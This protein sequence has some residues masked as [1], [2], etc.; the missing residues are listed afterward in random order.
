MPWRTVGID[1]V[2]L[3]AARAA[4]TQ[5]AALLAQ[6]FVP[7]GGSLVTGRNLTINLA[8]RVQNVV[9]SNATVTDAATVPLVAE[10]VWCSIMDR[11]VI[12]VTVADARTNVLLG[13]AHAALP[14]DVRATRPAAPGFATLVPRLLQAA[15][16]DATTRMAAPPA[17]AMHLGLALGSHVTRRDEGS[18]HC[19]NLLLEERL[20]KDYTVARNLGVDMLASVRRA[21]SLPP[22][23]RRPTRIANLRWQNLPEKTAKRTLPVTLTLHAQFADGVF[24]KTLP[25][26]ATSEWQLAAANGPAGGG[27]AL[28]PS[29]GFMQTLA[30]E[31]DTLKR[32][33]WP[34]IAKIDR[35][36]VYLDRGRA[37]GLRMRD[38]LLAANEQG[39]EVKG[40][41]VRFFGPEEKLTSP[42][43]FPIREGAIV[44][45]RKGQRDTRVGME[46]RMDP[47]TFPT[48][49]PIKPAE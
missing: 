14:R 47:R 30:D 22:E 44:Y 4:L 25:L 21:L 48:P 45:I 1:G 37:W 40:H 6:A 31:R 9:V 24:G 11:H 33:D 10:P 34:R 35:G 46:F 28:T 12:A 15:L 3:A 29:A 18:S 27:L 7:G 41:V 20:A 38:R 19:V 16:A 5:S 17:D 39:G 23:L 43:G 32:D 42:R 49:Y 26:A 36:W 2:E 13:A 8:R